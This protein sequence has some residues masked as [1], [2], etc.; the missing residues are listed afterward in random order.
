MVVAAQRRVLK[1]VQERSNDNCLE[2][3]I[4][5]RVCGVLD[6][7]DLIHSCNGR[8]TGCVFVRLALEPHELRP[9]RSK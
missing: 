9:I 8:F 1:N 6:N 4:R 3:I 2:V 5:R 7:G